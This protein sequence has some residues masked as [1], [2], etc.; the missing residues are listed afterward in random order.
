[1]PRFEPPRLLVVPGLNDS[2]PGHWQSW[3]QAQHRDALRV[4]QRDWSE[5]DLER[6]AERITHV[7]ALGGG[8]RFVAVAHSFGCLALA[9]HLAQQPDSPVVAALLVAPAE[10]DRF[11]IAGRLPPQRLP[12]S[13][14]LVASDTDPW[15]K[16]ASARRWAQRWGSHFV[17][18]G[19]AGHINVESGHGPL[20]LASR[21]VQTALQ[22]AAREQRIAH[23]EW[24]E[25]SFAV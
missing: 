9:R 24:G 16:P 17:N 13:T 25:W 18:L 15:M 20:P 21:W 6:W 5:P 12:R 22:R 8:R 19:D 2:G 3:L 23:A 1:M 7:A 10:P 11:G 4:R 14:T